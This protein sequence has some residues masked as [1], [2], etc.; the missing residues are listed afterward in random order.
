MNT[1]AANKRLNVIAAHAAKRMVQRCRSGSESAKAL[2]PA[3][4]D[5]CG[6]REGFA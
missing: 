5:D 2:G 3:G 4:S 1:S 6:M